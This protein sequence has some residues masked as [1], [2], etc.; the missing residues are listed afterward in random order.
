MAFTAEDE[1]RRDANYIDDR[2][3]AD[4]DAFDPAT[5]ASGRGLP[6]P[7]EPGRYR[8]VG[9][10]ACPFA[11]R[12]IIVRRLTGL[13]DALSLGLCGP[14]HDW[15][16]WTFDLYED[17]IDPVLGVGRLRDCFLRR[18]PEYDKG[19]TV[20]TLVDIGTK[21]AVTNDF[22]SLVADLAT[23]W[24]SLHWAGA[25]DLYPEP[26]RPQI[27]AMIDRIAGPINFGVYA[28]GLADDQDAHERAAAELFGALDELEAHL[29]EQ[30]YLVDDRITLA[31]V[32]L[33]ATLI[34]FDWAYHG[35][36]KCN[37][38]KIAEMPNLWGYLR[39]L[40]QTPGF[41]D[42]TNFPQIMEHYY[43]VIT[44]LNPNR[45]VPVGPDPA[46]LY[47]PHGRE[48]LGGSPFGDGVA[49]SAP[50]PED[51]LPGDERGAFA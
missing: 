41:G 33:Y 29:A 34:R 11:H 2:V 3:V 18:F 20:P 51:V 28:C 8:L 9:A 36:F 50:P 14:T 25:P 43:T 15:K 12:A 4:P 30:R 17:S 32:N 40:F 45:I 19:I 37:R 49:P 5:T 7:V 44:E 1:F 47:T 35:L 24:R 31:D 46:A 13:E 26:L 6:W 10:R 48:T 21:Q 39:D 16:S 23:E 42:T 27:D 22:T 38:A